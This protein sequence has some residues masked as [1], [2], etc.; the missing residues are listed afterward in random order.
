MS[1]KVL[2][3]TAY[4]KLAGNQASLEVQAPTVGSLL[5]E[6]RTQYPELGRHIC[7]EGGRRPR[8]LNV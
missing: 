8:Y 2:I 7:D 6:L 4:R 5:T 3:P 1:V